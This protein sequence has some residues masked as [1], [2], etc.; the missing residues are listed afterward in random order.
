[1]PIDNYGIYKINVYPKS[2]KSSYFTFCTPEDRTAIDSYLE[3][4]ERFGEHLKEDS[5][6]FR[7]D[8][9]AHGE[10]LRPGK[11]CSRVAVMRSMDGLLKDIGLRGTNP[12][13][14]SQRFNRSEIM[15]C[16]GFR[17]FFETNAFKAGMDH[18]YIRRLLGQK[19]GLEDAYLKLKEEEL[20]EGD[21]KHVG[22]IGIIDQLTINE[23]NR[24][25]RKVQEYKIKADKVDE[26][27]QEIA[28]LKKNLGL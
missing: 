25:K 17:K 6:V 10:P 22:F 4:W 7:T 12:E 26:A 18:I 23:E 21:S 11:P 3:H 19:S 24:L 13:L 8:Y 28:Q 15:R 1:M 2:K 9:N 20:L 16:H 14:E 27:L 5:P